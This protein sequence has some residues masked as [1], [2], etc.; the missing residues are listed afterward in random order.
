MARRRAITG[1]ALAVILPSILACGLGTPKG[2]PPSSNAPTVSPTTATSPTTASTSA[3]SSNC[4]LQYYPVVKSAS[5]SYTMTG[6]VSGQF[7]RS[8]TEVKPD[9]F[10]DQDVFSAGITRTGQWACDD[11]LIAL[12]P[13]AGISA[14]VQAKNLSGNFH[15]TDS[16]GVTIPDNLGPGATWNQDITIKGTESINGQEVPAK[17]HVIMQCN[18]SSV[19][20]ITVPAGKFDA[21]RAECKYDMKVTIT[22]NSLTVPTEITST[23]VAWYAAGVGMVKAEETI[24]SGLTTIEL[25]SYHIP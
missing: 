5:W 16:S 2:A 14:M 24:A 17:A 23:Q 25:A 19:E 4:D 15:T 18:A 1:I 8:I 12:Q 3:A 21:L 7:T 6:E 13:Q 22:L 11:G 20:P 10:T 9:G